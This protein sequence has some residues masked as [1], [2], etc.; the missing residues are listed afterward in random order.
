VEVIEDTDLQVRLVWEGYKDSAPEDLAGFRIY[1]V[2]KAEEGQKQEPFTL[3]AN[4]EDPGVEFYIDANNYPNSVIRFR[5]DGITRLYQVA[6][7]DKVDV[8]S[9]TVTLEGTSSN[10]PPTPPPQVKGTFAFGINTYEVRIEWRRNL[11]PDVIGYVV[12][13]IW[14]DEEGQVEFKK[15]IDNPNETVAIISDRYVAV[16]GFPLPKQYYVT[17]FDNTPK[18]DGKRDES[19]PSAILSGI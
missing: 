13:A 1:S 11:E 3:L 6:A 14:P 18:P 16:E 12:Y 4:I 17:A 15:K 2:P 5:E 9:D 10:L 8:E 7:F 19:G